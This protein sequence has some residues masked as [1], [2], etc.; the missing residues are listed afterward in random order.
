MGLKLIKTIGSKDYDYRYH[1]IT[2]AFKITYT[3]IKHQNWHFE[4]LA[5]N[6]LR[7]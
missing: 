1:Q 3:L 7:Y 4:Y 5:G 2:R 6:F